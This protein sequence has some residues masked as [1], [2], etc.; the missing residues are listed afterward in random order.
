[1]PRPNVC[2]TVQFSL[3]GG[4]F[5]SFERQAPFKCEQ[6]EARTRE[7]LANCIYEARALR[8]KP[9]EAP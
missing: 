5:L 9:P 8:D 6:D 1:M 7:W 4:E 2:M 3:E